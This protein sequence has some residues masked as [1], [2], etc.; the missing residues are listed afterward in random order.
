[1]SVFVSV[2]AS[3]DLPAA[4][5]AAVP[6]TV[7]GE[8]QFDATVTEITVIPE[9]P[10]TES[11]SLYRTMTFYNRGATGVGTTVLGTIVTNTVANGGSGSW[12]AA[13]E[14]NVPL[15]ATVANRNITAND[16]IECVE[17]VAS[18]GT[19]RTECK[20]VVKGTRR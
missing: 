15:T 10:L 6:E 19:A 18:T 8:A 2:I 9:G 16:V 4:I 13:D 11:T 14:M 17:T 5:A 3:A 20:V 7:I 1:M 12:S